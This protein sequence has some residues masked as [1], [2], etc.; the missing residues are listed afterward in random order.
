MESY[1]QIFSDL[2]MMGMFD[3][4]QN[5]L[6]QEKKTTVTQQLTLSPSKMVNIHIIN[7][8]F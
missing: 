5:T 4:M 6:P 8:S 2:T 1:L 7:H 3:K